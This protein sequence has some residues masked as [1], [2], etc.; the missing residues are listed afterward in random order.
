MSKQSH[1]VDSF[2]QSVIIANARMTITNIYTW[3]AY[4]WLFLFIVTLSWYVLIYSNIVLM[5]TAILLNI[6][7]FSNFTI[8]SWQWSYGSRIYNCLCNHC[9]SP[10]MSRV[11]ITIRASCTTL[12][13]K[14]FQWLPTGRFFSGSSGFLH[15]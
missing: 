2:Y 11:R 12:C 4:V 15:Q 10:L 3:S 13:D 7:L 6:C 8:T 1:S 9:L 5:P 14:V